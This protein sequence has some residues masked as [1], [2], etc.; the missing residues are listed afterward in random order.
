MIL[1]IVIDR[2]TTVAFIIMINAVV[3]IAIII[4]SIM[5]TITII[6]TIT[7]TVTVTITTMAMYITLLHQDN[8]I[9]LLAAMGAS[10]AAEAADYVLHFSTRSVG[11]SVAR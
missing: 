8:F 1:M 3:I 11:G 6:T 4:K 2:R 5:I 7:V 10:D 9:G